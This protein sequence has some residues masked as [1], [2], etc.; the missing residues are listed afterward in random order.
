MLGR[1]NESIFAEKSWLSL[2]F[3][4]ILMTSYFCATKPVS[5]SVSEVILPDLGFRFE[6]E[7]ILSVQGKNICSYARSGSWYFL[8][9]FLFF[10]TQSQTLKIKRSCSSFFLKIILEHSV[11]EGFKKI[12]K[13]IMENS[14]IGGGGVSKG[15]FPHIIFFPNGLKINFIH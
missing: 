12:K 6:K 15:H 1:S 8:S 5:Q 2:L 7:K 10:S 14:I 3:A 11:R 4:L 13:K 9:L